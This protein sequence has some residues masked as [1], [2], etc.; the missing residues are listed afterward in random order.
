MLSIPDGLVNAGAK[1]VKER[2]TDHSGVITKAI[3]TAN[4]RAWQAVVIDNIF[5]HVTNFF[6]DGDLKAVQKQTLK[7]VATADTGLDGVSDELRT[8]ACNELIAHK[9]AGQFGVEGAALTALDLTRFA[10][11]AKVA[12]D[13][14]GPSG[15]S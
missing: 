14:H 8:K 10:S 4:D 7:F 11:S 3:A 9:K 6:R 13:A 2:F 5:S 15:T 12:E 1:W